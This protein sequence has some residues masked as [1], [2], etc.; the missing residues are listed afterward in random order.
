MA[1]QLKK[2]EENDNFKRVTNKVPDE[3]EEERIERERDAKISMWNRYDKTF[4]VT[5]SI[6]SFNGGLKFL[7]M[8]S[9]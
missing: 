8:L 6:Q 4:L 2:D 7:F 9:Y 1:A 3:T 5:F